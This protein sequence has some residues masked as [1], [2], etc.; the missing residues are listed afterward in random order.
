VPAPLEKG[1]NDV[2]EGEAPSNYP[3]R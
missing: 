1:G 3:F 2:F